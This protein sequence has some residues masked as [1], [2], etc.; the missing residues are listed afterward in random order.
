MKKIIILSLT[1]FLLI[2]SAVILIFGAM[3]NNNTA[4]IVGYI[5][6]AIVSIL[7]IVSGFIRWDEGK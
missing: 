4:R 1:I 7:N 3:K 5:L 2:V 6:L